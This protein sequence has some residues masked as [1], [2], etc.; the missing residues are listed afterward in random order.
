MKIEHVGRKGLGD[1]VAFDPDDLQ[2]EVEGVVFLP[3]E[4]LLSDGGE[5]HPPD[6]I[7]VE[8]P[9]D[10]TPQ[11]Q[12]RHSPRHS[13]EPRLP[14]EKEEADHQRDRADD[15]D[16]ADRRPHGVGQIHLP[17]ELLQHRRGA[18]GAQP[19]D[20]LKGNDEP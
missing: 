20:Q 7:V 2:P 3:G 1:A 9:V 17:R 5:L 16:D 15:P 10:A 12:R 19:F 11:R 6:P 18:V 13:G 4:D 8:Q 14:G